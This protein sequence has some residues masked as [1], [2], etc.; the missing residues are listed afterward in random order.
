M[1]AEK[2]AKTRSL[3]L[4]LLELIG[5]K[6]NPTAHI[7]RQRLLEIR[8]FLNYVVRTYPSLNPCLKGLH[9]T[10]NG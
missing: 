6:A 10:I 1:S 5:T 8:G 7:Q 3:I 2:W 4:E 9:L